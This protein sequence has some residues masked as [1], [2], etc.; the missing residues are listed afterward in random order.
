MHGS[1]GAGRAF[2]IFALLMVGVMVLGSIVVF[3]GSIFGGTAHDAVPTR[4]E[5]A[6]DEEV[7]ELETRVAEN[8]D[9]GESAAV[10]A[11]IYAQ[12][13]R[14]EEAFPLFERAL[15]QDPDDAGVRLAF[16]IAL[17]RS[18]NEFDARVQLERAYEL[19]SDKSGPA[20]YL[21]Q[22]EENREEPDLDAARRWYEI[23]IE[24]SPD[25]LV[26]DQAR[27]RLEELD[28][29]PG[30]EPTPTAE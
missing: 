1:K 21:G 14:N 8:P 25:S 17:F 3:G 10:L 5:D 15:E 9:D 4:G 29:E 24:A 6:L 26:A 18:G 13:G 22:L 11:N 19:E 27:T 23:A 7:R 20:Y 28:A 12:E 30:D 16:G 2:T